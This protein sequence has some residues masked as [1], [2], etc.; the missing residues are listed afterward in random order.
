MQKP[1]IAT[2]SELWKLIRIIEEQ[3]DPSHKRTTPEGYIRLKNGELV[4]L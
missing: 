2:P 3:T 4:K 1:K